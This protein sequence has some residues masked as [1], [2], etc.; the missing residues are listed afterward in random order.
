[1]KKI[2]ANIQ[3]VRG[4]MKQVTGY[5]TEVKLE[6]GETAEMLIH[7]DTVYPDYWTV[8]EYATGINM[9]PSVS[10]STNVKTRSGALE[11]TLEFLN[12]KLKERGITLHE[13]RQG[14]LK[15]NNLKYVN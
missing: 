11:V 10:D 14:F 2:K 12:R 13:A 5:Y 3:F 9:T 1:M 15:S 8:S 6:T 4:G 7:R